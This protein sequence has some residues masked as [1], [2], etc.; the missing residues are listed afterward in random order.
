M[1]YDMAKAFAH[2]KMDKLAES[3]AGQ[4]ITGNVLTAG[5]VIF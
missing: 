1:A 2:N 4:A 3:K 5:V